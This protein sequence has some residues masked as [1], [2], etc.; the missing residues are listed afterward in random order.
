MGYCDILNPEFREDVPHGCLFEIGY[1][2]YQS[3]CGCDRCRD[4]ESFE[5]MV[6]GLYAEY[7][8]MTQEA[9]QE[10]FGGVA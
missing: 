7:A 5:Q 3:E 10:A 2:L 4:E 1:A 9:Y 8:G 6:E